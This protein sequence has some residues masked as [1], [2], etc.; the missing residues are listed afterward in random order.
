MLRQR[1]LQWEKRRRHLEQVGQC[2]S[3]FYLAVPARLSSKC[4]C[5]Q[6]GQT[7]PHVLKLLL[8]ED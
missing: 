1:I 7:G 4:N 5:Q 2:L 6:L 8:N 3:Q